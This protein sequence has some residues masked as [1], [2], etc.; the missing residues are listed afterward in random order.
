M[1]AEK[2]PIEVKNKYVQMV[3]SHGSIQ[4]SMGATTIER[5]LDAD[6]V[7]ELCL[8][9]DAKRKSR[10]PTKM[11]IKE[12]FSMMTLP[13]PNPKAGHPSTHKVWIC[14]SAGTN[15]V[16]TGYFSSIVPEIWDHIAAF[17]M[18]PAAQV[19]WWLCRMGHLMEDVN[20]LIRHCFTISQ[21]QRVTKSKYRK[22]LGYAVV[23]DQDA[24]NIINA[25]TT[26]GIYDLTLGLSN[27]EKRM[28]AIGKIHAMSAITYGETKEGS[29]EAYNF[30]SVQSVTSTH[31]INKKKKAT[32]TDAL[33]R[34]LAKSVYSIDT[35]TSKVMADNRED[36]VDD[37]KD[38]ESNNSDD[39]GSNT[40]GKTVAIEG[41]GILDGKTVEHEVA[42]TRTDN[43][44]AMKDAD[45]QFSKNTTSEEEFQD[46]G[47]AK[48]DANLLRRMETTEG[49]IDTSESDN[50]GYTTP[51]NLLSSDKDSKTYKDN[52]HPAK[53]ADEEL[54]ITSYNSSVTKVD[55]GVFNAYH[56]QRY[57]EPAN[58]CQAL[59][60]EAGP[61][62]GA[63]KVML[64]MIRTEFEGELLG[65]KA[66]LTHFSQNLINLLIKESG[67]DP[68][69]MIALLD[70]NSADISQ[71]K[72]QYNEDKDIHK[73]V[74][75][76]Q[77][78]LPPDKEVQQSVA[79]KTQGMVLRA[80]EATPAEGIVTTIDTM[81]GDKEG[82]QSVSMAPGG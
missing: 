82:L 66:D 51:I 60:N 12:I 56:A 50:G 16:A 41:M 38:E 55:S 59:W 49:L 63:M 13:N 44:K 75:K 11:T 23:N 37:S 65:M 25:A 52:D 39:T 27:K 46:E 48:A 72:E 24:E 8:L 61:T 53:L 26:Q 18:C 79:S 17:T 77:D 4:L 29:M 19:Y 71:Y 10:Q 36:E 14:L 40:G 33:V 67:E 58:F 35:G 2:D 68:N 73:A 62:V 70:Q 21:Q 5:M 28:M 47:L 69:D 1:L 57:V 42:K 9:P 81:A 76:D 64:E 31:S 6:T 32:K 7:F 43:D 54:D 30:S 34:S 80:P 22:D 15:G 78:A 45:S 20:R 74:T 3:Q